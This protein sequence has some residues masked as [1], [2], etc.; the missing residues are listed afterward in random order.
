MVRPFKMAVPLL[1]LF[2]A[3]QALIHSHDYPILLI[4]ELT[5]LL[6]SFLNPPSAAGFS[7]N[8]W[9]NLMITSNLPWFVDQRFQVFMQ[10]C[11]LQHWTLLSPPD[12]STI[13]CLICFGPAFSFFL[14]PFLL[15]PSSILDTYRPKL[16]IFQ[17]HIFLPFHTVHRVLEARILKWFAILFSSRPHF[18]GTLHHD[19]SVLGGPAHCSCLQLHKTAIHVFILVSFPWLWFSFWR[20]W[21][22]S[23]CFFCLFSHG[24]IKFHV[25]AFYV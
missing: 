3:D 24:N 12:T 11:S 21:D 23:S 5:Q 8:W 22:C 15:F 10:Y 4:I 18:V 13:G 1:S 16:F 19:T 20:L 17:G 9:A 14:K 25:L 6:P 7:G 2:S